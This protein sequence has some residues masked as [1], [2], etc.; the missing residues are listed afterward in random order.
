MWK[1]WKSNRYFILVVAAA[2]NFVHGNPYIWTVFQPYMQKE[3]G[4]STA[5]SSQPF[6]L[7]IGVF[8]FG[9]MIGGYLQ[10]RIGAKKTMLYGS[11]FM[12][13]GFLMA[14][15]A[16][17][18]APWMVSLGYGVIGG[19]GSGCAFSML[20]AV[21][22]G[23]FPDKRGLVTGI[24]IGVIGI[25]GVVM[26]PLC[27]WILS[28]KG[29]HFAML[30]VTVIYA[31]L[32]LGGF[33]LEEAP[34]EI[35]RRGTGNGEMDEMWKE[36]EREA[37]YRSGNDEDQALLLD[38]PGNGISGAGVCT[39][40]SSD[41]VSGHGKGPYGGAGAGRCNDRVGGKHCRPC[42]GAVAV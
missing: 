19:L 6:T 1:E 41:E 13:L 15:L 7:I 17:Q 9:N 12:C 16:P 35:Q 37:V 32:C 24:T 3:F 27:D 22:Q 20:V 31:V 30:I 25:S 10:H 2:V 36:K 18:D 11:L 29:F 34:E 38:Q 40:Q 42:G 23:W 8:A 33:F 39:G 26:N 21:P 28:R 4:V 5:V 14:A